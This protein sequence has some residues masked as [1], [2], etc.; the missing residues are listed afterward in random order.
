MHK[1]LTCNIKIHA[2]IRDLPATKNSRIHKEEIYEKENNPTA[3]PYDLRCHD[4]QYTVPDL[5]VRFRRSGNMTSQIYSQTGA[6]SDCK[7]AVFNEKATWYASNPLTAKTARIITYATPFTVFRVKPGKLS[8]I[9]KIQPTPIKSQ[10]PQPNTVSV[11]TALQ[12]VKKYT[13][14][15]HL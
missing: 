6:L 13:D 14:R 9:Q 5:C 1:R 3:I 2:Y 11:H 15:I 12:T 8:A 7:P 4:C 10:A